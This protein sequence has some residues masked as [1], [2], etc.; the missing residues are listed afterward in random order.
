MPK[1]FARV[2]VTVAVL[3]ATPGVSEAAPR[4][5]YVDFGICGAPCLIN[6]PCVI[7]DPII[8]T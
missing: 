6:C 5:V 3:L 1:V 4:P 2:A 8:I 7:L